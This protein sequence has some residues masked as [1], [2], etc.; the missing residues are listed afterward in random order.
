[1]QYVCQKMRWIFCAKIT[2][3]FLKCYF[4]N[5]F[6][7]GYKYYLTYVLYCTVVEFAYNC[8]NFCLAKV[9]LKI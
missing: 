8:F 6:G 2:P 9:T 1:M 7:Y 5:K 3:N 4:C